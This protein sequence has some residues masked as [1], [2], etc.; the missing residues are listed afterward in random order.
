MAGRIQIIQPNQSSRV[1]PGPQ[2]RATGADF[3]TGIGSGSGVGLVSF[4]AELYKTTE[5]QEVTSAHTKIAQA[6][7]EWSV[8]LAERVRRADAFDPNFAGKIVQEY[9]DYLSKTAAG[10]GAFTRAGSNALNRGLADL[11]AD[12][13]RQAGLYQVKLA[14]ERAAIDFADMVDANRNVVLNDPTQYAVVLQS[15]RAAMNDPN[16][17]YSRM[18]A[19][20]RIK[21]GAMAEKG[22]ALSAIQGTIRMDPE[23]AKRQIA[24]GMW[25]EALDPDSTASALNAA[26]TAIRGREA[27]RRMLEGEERRKIEEQK[28]A[29][30]SQIWND[31]V[32][33]K[34][35]TLRAILDSNLDRAEKNALFEA[36]K[37][38]A[39]EGDKDAKT[40]G[41][42]FVEMLKRI[43]TDAPL[44]DAQI[45]EQVGKGLT[46]AGANQLFA[47]KN[48]RK[49][50]EGAANQNILNSFLQGAEEQF[51]GPV[52][53]G[54][55]RYSKGKSLYAEWLQYALPEIQKGMDAGKPLN[56]ILDP[57]GPIAQSILVRKPTMKQFME[58]INGQMSGMGTAPP[59]DPIAKFLPNVAPG[60]APA[61]VT[62]PIAPLVDVSKA[63]RTGKDRSGRAVYEIDGKW[64]YGDG[65][66]YK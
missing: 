13:A 62:V 22:L 9:D 19:S 6:R 23:L 18:P 53:F 35:G 7:A 30:S 31:I 58:D 26:D 61:S 34:P 36:M 39:G 55:P 51:T 52:V 57:K 60:A 2:P 29:L 14:G 49:T 17:S 56:E 48:G 33:G 25:N 40:Y 59:A 21:L 38:R 44:T 65:S 66:A 41:P 24:G 37:G 32:E 15:L 45:Y 4:G 46:T 28:R 3:Q 11:R 16:S 5:E 50:S 12:I 20:E 8:Y 54:L 27:E 47:W 42:S 1:G 10:S 43:P 64:V 63:T